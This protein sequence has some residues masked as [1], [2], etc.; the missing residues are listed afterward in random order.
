MSVTEQPMATI[1]HIRTDHFPISQNSLRWPL[2]F[3]ICRD[4]YVGQPT[5]HPFSFYIGDWRILVARNPSSS[6]R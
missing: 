5:I 4:L 2:A 3:S 1:F 6:V